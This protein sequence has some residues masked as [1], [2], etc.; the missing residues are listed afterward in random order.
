MKTVI[1]TLMFLILG[2]LFFI[3]E[4]KSI[5]IEEVD[6][7]I[8]EDMPDY[9][10]CQEVIDRNIKVNELVDKIRANNEYF[11]QNE[12]KPETAYIHP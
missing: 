11:K 7:F 12:T 3:P 4:K 6:R 10:P 8:V 2:V 1:G 5:E 9:H